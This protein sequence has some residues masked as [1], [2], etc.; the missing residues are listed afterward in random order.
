MYILPS[1]ATLIFVENHGRYITS[2]SLLIEIQVS[3]LAV[4][5]MLR[6]S[7]NMYSN[8]ITCLHFCS[9][10]Q[11][12]A[13]S[14]YNLC[15]VICHDATLYIIHTLQLS[16]PLLLSISKSFAVKCSLL[17]FTTVSTVSY[18]GDTVIVHM[19]R[20]HI[21]LL[22]DDEQSLKVSSLSAVKSTTP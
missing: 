4:V 5:R 10:S 19:P 15:N 20:V 18:K 22:P 16:H 3:I 6:V 12:Y 11:K 1:L 9:T 14:N 2:R 21:C 7:Y 17:I 13:S 8:L